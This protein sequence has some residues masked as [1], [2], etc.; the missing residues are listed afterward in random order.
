M[1]LKASIVNKYKKSEFNDKA[2][3]VQDKKAKTS[4]A[5]NI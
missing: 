1:Q 2:E 3:K 5:I 4:S